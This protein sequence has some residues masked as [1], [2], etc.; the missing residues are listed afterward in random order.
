MQ[1]DL[2]RQ[3]WWQCNGPCQSRPPYYGKVKRSSNRAPSHNDLWWAE[4]QRACG[5]TF[6]KVKEPQSFSLKEKKRK[7]KHGD[8]KQLLE[9]GT[10]KRMDSSST[11]V[12]F[13]GRGHVLD[14][15]KRGGGGDTCD[16]TESQSIRE[17]AL[18]AA[19]QRLKT[20]QE[21]GKRKKPQTGEQLRRVVARKRC[22]QDDSH[23]I[24]SIW[25]RYSH[26]RAESQSQKRTKMVL[27]NLD[28]CEEVAAD[29]NSSDD[30]Y[31]TVPKQTA[32]DEDCVIVVEDDVSSS[33]SSQHSSVPLQ[34]C[35]VCLRT[36]IPKTVL[37]IHVNI[38]LEE[39]KL[40][41]NNVEVA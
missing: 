33:S 7:P 9:A 27:D 1:V 32:A 13:S 19:E 24:M 31:I 18:A 17:K 20:N 8:I 3:H 5:G 16:L 39:M 21:K 40:T 12:S 6:I 35:P 28:D 38:C 41:D 29:L 4:H 23:D 37:S 15:Q 25:N 10:S 11:T 30:G 22:C 34:T 14:H 36:D 2:Y 26:E